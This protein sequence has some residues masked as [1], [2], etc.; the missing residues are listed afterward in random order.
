M[1][2]IK[3]IDIYPIVSLLIFT[4]FF[5]IIIIRVVRM[6][7]NEIEELS[8]LPIDNSDDKYKFNN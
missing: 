6:P 7:K 1:T 4:V 8:N 2:S 3:G 5:A